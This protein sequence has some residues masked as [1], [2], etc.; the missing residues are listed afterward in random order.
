MR[1]LLMQTA[2]DFQSWAVQFCITRCQCGVSQL[3]PSLLQEM[4][5]TSPRILPQSSAGKTQGYF[6]HHNFTEY[7]VYLHILT[8]QCSFK[9]QKP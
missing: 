5:H 9:T 7:I 2:S 4:Y 6:Q 3:P 8:C 1:S